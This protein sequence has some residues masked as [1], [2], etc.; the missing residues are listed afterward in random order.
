MHRRALTHD[1]WAEVEEDLLSGFVDP[2]RVAIDVG[3]NIGR[4]TTRLSGLCRHVYALEPEL[5]YVRFL[6][7]ALP[8][9]VSVLAVGAGSGSSLESYA[10]PEIEGDRIPSLGRIE[11]LDESI[12]RTT[13]VTVPL[14]IFTPLPVGF[15]KIDVEGYEEE[16]IAGA[17]NLIGRWKPLLLIE[18]EER[19]NP[20]GLDRIEASLRELKYS[21][22]FFNAG[23]MLPLA[24]LTP[25]LQD[26]AAL[27]QPVARR[28]MA[29]VN[30]FFF[31][32]QGHQQETYFSLG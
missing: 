13:V 27:R 1:R 22:Y 11:P 31:V 8:K 10:V 20:G 18:I 9:N 24:H 29:Y 23:K 30:N 19:H 25:A 32:P 17:K 5:E 2:D 12:S 16:V 7:R 21:G 26:E 28:H 6:Y 3:A 4:Y 14:D 15:I